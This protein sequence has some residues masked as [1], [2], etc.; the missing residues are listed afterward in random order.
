M[1]NKKYEYEYLAVYV[2]TE[3]MISG[4]GTT[5][6]VSDSYSL[7]FSD[8]MDIKKAIKEEQGFKSVTITNIIPLPI[9]HP[10][11]KEQETLKDNGVQV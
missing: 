10:N 7:Y 1:K 9:T 6:F 2:Y 5:S 4:T 11:H 3:C 8:I